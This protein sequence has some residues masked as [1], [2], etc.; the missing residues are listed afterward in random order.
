M[1]VVDIL[2]V[3]CTMIEEGAMRNFYDFESDYKQTKRLIISVSES[4]SHLCLL[5]SLYPL[6]TR[7][8]N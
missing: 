3:F 2:H 1:T 8:I 7:E 6:R 5:G 4:C